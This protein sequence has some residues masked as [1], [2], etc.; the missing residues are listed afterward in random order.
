MDFTPKC[1]N[2]CLPSRPI[3]LHKIAESTHRQVRKSW[4]LSGQNFTVVLN[5]G[6]TTR[7]ETVST[8]A[9]KKDWLLAGVLATL[10]G[11]LDTKWKVQRPNS[12]EMEGLKLWFGA[13]HE[14]QVEVEEALWC[15]DVSPGWGI[16]IELSHFCTV[17][18]LLP[19]AWVTPSVCGEK[20]GKNSTWFL[21]SMSANEFTGEHFLRLYLDCR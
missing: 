7:K 11:R 2:K 14:D 6:E 5:S 12:L 15:S 17:R 19:S 8:Q 3:C 20:L 18:S 9:Q 16:A 10:T 4:I 21:S 1:L 13:A